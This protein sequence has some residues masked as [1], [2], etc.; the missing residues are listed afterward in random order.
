[1]DCFPELTRMLFCRILDKREAHEADEGLITGHRPLLTV[2]KESAFSSH[3][4]FKACCGGAWP[5]I[6]RSGPQRH[7]GCG[8]GW[9]RA[10]HISSHEGAWKPVAP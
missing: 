2:A 1:M 8:L 4:A 5:N 10:G 9:K 7:L 3:R 6:S